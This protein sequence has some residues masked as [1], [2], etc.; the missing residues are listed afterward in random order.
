M[1]VLRRVEFKNTRIGCCGLARKDS[2]T[3]VG[4]T[5]EFTDFEKDA[6][7]LMKN[8]GKQSYE[9]SGDEYSI[10]YFEGNSTEQNFREEGLSLFKFALEKKEWKFYE[11]GDLKFSVSN[12]AELRKIW[13][14]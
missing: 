4:Y 9:G 14:L 5:A 12:S 10:E 6:Y 2:I 3:P 7:D 13:Q 1:I 8:Y 11:R